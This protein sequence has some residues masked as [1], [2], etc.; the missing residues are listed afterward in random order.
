MKKTPSRSSFGWEIV[1]K[2][3]LVGVDEIAA[4]MNRGNEAP[5]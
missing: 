1:K 2:Q 3:K 4:D 5:F